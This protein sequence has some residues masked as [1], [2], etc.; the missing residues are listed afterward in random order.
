[1]SLVNLYLHSGTDQVSK[2]EREDFISNI[3]NILLYKKKNGLLGGD[4]N[5]IVEKKDALNYPEQKISKCF[6][7]TD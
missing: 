1:M 3:P 7:K 6:K 4:M 2:S 5:S